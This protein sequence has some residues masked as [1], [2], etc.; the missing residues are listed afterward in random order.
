MHHHRLWTIVGL[1]AA[2]MFGGALPAQAA[3]ITYFADIKRW[4]G[5]GG[6]TMWFILA[7]SILA[8]AFTIERLIRMRKARIVPAKLANEARR[9]W[10][11]GKHDEIL[12]LC[13]ASDSVL[14]RAI[15]RLVMHRRVPMADVRSI[16][17]DSISAELSLHYRRIHPISVAAMVAP[18]LGLFGTVSGMI[19]AFRQFRALGE[20][21]D[22]GVFAGAISVALITTQAGLIVAVPALAISHYFRNRTNAYVDELDGIVQELLLEWYLPAEQTP[23]TK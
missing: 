3:S 7:C 19:T 17:G 12:A 6:N 8:V 18:L 4:F 9:L 2:G 15:R 11:E 5:D 21:G 14:A 16:V 22:P 13:D 10:R 20:T 1:A 23:P